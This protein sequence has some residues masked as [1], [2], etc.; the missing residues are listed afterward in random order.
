MNDPT[1]E[2][3]GR[4]ADFALQ[5]TGHGLTAQPLNL[6]VVD[7]GKAV[8]ILCLPRGD[9]GGKLWFFA[10]AFARWLSEADQPTWAITAL[11]TLL[12]ESP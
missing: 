11:K 9:D 12:A 2:Q 4:L 1:V 3:A 5:L 6:L 7:D 8:T 10:P